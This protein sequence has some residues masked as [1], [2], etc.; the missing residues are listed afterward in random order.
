MAVVQVSD[1]STTIKVSSLQVENS[2]KVISL[3]LAPDLRQQKQNLF[4]GPL[5]NPAEQ[6][7]REALESLQGLRQVAHAQILHPLVFGP[8]ADGDLEHLMLDVF[9][10]GRL[11]PLLLLGARARFAL[12]RSRC[13]EQGVD[14]GERAVLLLQGPVVGVVLQIVVLK[15]DPA[16]RLEVTIQSSLAHVY[17]QRA[18]TKLN[19]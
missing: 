17:L 2:V 9:E 12:Q 4:L 7:E 19:S 6:A 5:E 11:H 8:R 14:P 1:S 13:V 10:P 15:L 18:L 16:A 3:Q